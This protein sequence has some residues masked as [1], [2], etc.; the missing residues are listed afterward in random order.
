M[1]IDGGSES[2]DNHSDGGGSAHDYH[3]QGCGGNCTTTVIVG[4]EGSGTACADE[5]LQV[6][7]SVDILMLKGWVFA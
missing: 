1:T 3:S 2:S 7:T 5:T 4:G 6:Q